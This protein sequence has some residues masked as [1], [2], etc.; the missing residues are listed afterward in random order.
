MSLFCMRAPLIKVHIFYS[1]VNTMAKN[2]DQ[3]VKWRITYQPLKLKVLSAQALRVK[4][5]P[6]GYT[7][8][9]LSDFAP[10]VT[11]EEEKH[12]WKLFNSIEDIDCFMQ[13]NPHCKTDTKLQ[14]QYVIESS[15]TRASLV[16][17]GIVRWII[18]HR[19]PIDLPDI[20]TE[21]ICEGFTDYNP[22][23]MDYLMTLDYFLD[24]DVNKKMREKLPKRLAHIKMTTGKLN[25]WDKFNIDLTYS[26]FSHMLD[27]RQDTCQRYIRDD[28]VIAPTESDLP[29]WFNTDRLGKTRQH[30]IAAS[31]MLTGR[32]SVDKVAFVLKPLKDNKETATIVVTELVLHSFVAFMPDRVYRANGIAKAFKSERLDIM[33]SML[34][35]LSKSEVK[36]AIKPLDIYGPW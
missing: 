11:M 25:I 26:E 14:I 17:R 15:N 5:Y 16:F 10:V 27:R 23:Y 36:E 21:L 12:I 32:I 34:G 29:G 13:H 9:M 22:Y 19:D 3:I 18:K 7:I 35:R 20:M 1:I 6:I 4:G 28:R 31:M 33:N 8:W 2:Q 24:H 30:L